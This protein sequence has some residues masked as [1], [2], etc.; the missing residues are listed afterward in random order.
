MSEQV[1]S[2]IM[3]TLLKEINSRINKATGGITNIS[4]EAQ[5]KALVEQIETVIDKYD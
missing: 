1:D 2:E 3:V 5:L 4:A